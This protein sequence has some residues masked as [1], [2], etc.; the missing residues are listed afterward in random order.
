MATNTTTQ[1]A[2]A[3]GVL[4]TGFDYQ[5]RPVMGEVVGISRNLN[6]SI[7]FIEVDCGPERPA[8]RLWPERDDWALC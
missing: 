6:S 3:L 7:M 1:G 8:A 4:V 2:T 5:E